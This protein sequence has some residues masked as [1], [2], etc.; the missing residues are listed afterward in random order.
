MKTFKLLFT[1]L[2]IVSLVTG[3]SKDDLAPDQN[4]D[5]M[6]KKAS[7]FP[8]FLVEPNGT[9]D[10][11]NLKNAFIDAQA[12]GPGAIVQLCEGEYHLGLLQVYGFEGCLKGAGKDKTIITALNNLDIQS[13]WDQN[14][15]GDLVKFVGGDVHLSQFT[16]QTPPGKVAATGT[17]GHFGTLINFSSGNAIVPGNENSSINVEIDNVRFRGQSLEGGIYGYNCAFGV[18]AG[19]DWFN[20][21]NLPREKVNLKITNSEFDTFFYGLILESVTNG[22]VIIGA[23]G[24]GNVIS[25]SL[26]SGGVFESRN[27]KI[28]IQ[29]NTFNIPYRSYG[30][31]LDINT[32]WMPG[33]LAEQPQGQA[34]ICNV[35]NNSF[36]LAKAYNGLWM[37]DYR[38]R[39]N[40]EELPVV[41]Q[42]KNNRFKLTEGFGRAMRCRWTK[43]TV[44]RNNKI[45]GYGAWGIQIDSPGGEVFNENGLLLGNNFANAEFINGSVQLSADTKNW[46]IV[47]GNIGETVVDYGVNNIITGFNN[48]TSET[49]L[50]QTIVDNLDEMRSFLD[51]IK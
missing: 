29:G 17:N 30:F 36:N 43:G 34:T 3:C 2:T 18:R 45:E 20:P 10:T 26:Y 25:N 47:G 24:H 35:Q 27:M 15:R 14:L 6:L 38:R 33:Q 31:M 8:V 46:T 1:I 49:P 22:K 21:I 41:F 32:P 9:D 19:W 16:I 11:E 39:T 37:I 5:L 48:Q 50:G 12:A 23:S 40:P 28:L 13:L 44:I 7:L 42:V 51:L 4:N